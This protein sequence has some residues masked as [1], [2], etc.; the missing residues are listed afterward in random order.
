MTD[1]DLTKNARCF[2]EH[3]ARW[4][5]ASYQPLWV[6][7]ANFRVAFSALEHAVTAAEPP[8]FSSSRHTRA[9][10]PTAIAIL[11]WLADAVSVTGPA[12]RLFLAIRVLAVHE[13]IAVIVHPILAGKPCPFVGERRPAILGTET[14]ALIDLAD[15][16]PTAR[17]NNR[18]ILAAYAAV[19]ASI[20]V[21][22]DGI[23]PSARPAAETLAQQT[24]LNTVAVV[25]TR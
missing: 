4:V 10:R 11:T 23:A 21:A 2:R 8:H 7:V 24:S 17:F 3:R 12:K 6:S 22:R 5:R 9:I 25:R 19:V 20:I 1:D 15:S 13:T 18:L 14:A 16:I